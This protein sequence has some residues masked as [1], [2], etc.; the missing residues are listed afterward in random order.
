MKFILIVML[1][2]NM[3]Y[4]KS[5][6]SESNWDFNV[7]VSY[8][9]KKENTQ[10]I[11]DELGFLLEISK[12]IYE[13]ENTGTMLKLN[14]GDEIYLAD[15]DNWY[16]GIM[17]EQKINKENKISLSVSANLQMA[18]DSSEISPGYSFRYTRFF[19]NKNSGRGTVNLFFDIKHIQRKDIEDK[20]SNTF[21]TIGLNVPF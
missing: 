13:I 10:N 17:I 11:D 15:N 12:G 14:L 1:L 21:G 16:T 4:G 8:N 3:L 2:T 9:S 20:F 7:G 18:N 6:W 19:Y 5:L